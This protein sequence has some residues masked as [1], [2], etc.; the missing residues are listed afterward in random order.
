MKKGISLILVILILAS[1]MGASF[2]VSEI[3]FRRQKIVKGDESSEIAYYA[4][5]TAVELGLYHLNKLRTDYRDV[6]DIRGE[7]GEPPAIYKI[8]EVRLKETEDKENQY[9]FPFSLEPGQSFQIDLDIEGAN[10]PQEIRIYF[11]SDSDPEKH[12]VILYS[13]MKRGARE[14]LQ[15]DCKW[16]RSA[17]SSSYV[18]CF[19]S[20]EYY[21]F[22]IKVSNLSEKETSYYL[23][24]WSS[25]M[26]G[27]R[28]LS[29]PISTPIGFILRTSGQFHGFTRQNE[30]TYDKWQIYGGFTEEASN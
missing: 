25:R 30:I 22:K 27:Q 5:E 13:E 24:G 17:S 2:A 3:I 21:Y 26:N 18:R 6:F 15:E 8:D 9:K 10:Y 4:A 29:I 7:I 28:P 23:Q 20:F 11:L 14:I 1:L 19:L 12:S 16:E